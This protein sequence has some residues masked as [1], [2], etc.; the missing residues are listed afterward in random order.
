MAVGRIRTL[1][2]ATPGTDD[3]HIQK[4]GRESSARGRGQENVAGIQIRM[5]DVVAVKLVEKFSDG[6]KETGAL[7]D[8][9]A[10]GEMLYKIPTFGNEDRDHFDAAKQAG[11]IKNDRFDPRSG[12]FSLRQ[13][14]AGPDFTKSATG[15]EVKIPGHS[16]PPA[17]MG[18]GSDHPGFSVTER[19]SKHG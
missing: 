8:A 7:C 3:I 18:T 13:S 12:D 4:P 16:P 6:G 11:R 9:G 1:V 15:A 19:R 10:A 14:L 2:S 5:T 17:T